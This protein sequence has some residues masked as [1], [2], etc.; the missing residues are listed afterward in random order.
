[1]TDY[2][3]GILITFEKEVCAESFQNYEKIFRN[4]KNVLSITPYIKSAEDW[5][6]E[7]KGREESFREMKEFLIQKGK[8]K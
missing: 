1:M 6:S 3:K 7:A 5:M 4:I 8:R 2:Y